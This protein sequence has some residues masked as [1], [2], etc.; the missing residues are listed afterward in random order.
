MSYNDLPIIRLGLTLK[1]Y[2]LKYSLTQHD[3]AKI[4]GINKNYLGNIERGEVN[5]GLTLLGEI[6]RKLKFDQTELKLI[7]GI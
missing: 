4:L 5:V 3:L 1:K 7:F 6:I 2:R